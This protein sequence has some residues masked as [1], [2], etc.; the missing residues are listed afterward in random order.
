MGRNASSRSGAA[1]QHGMAQLNL[2]QIGGGMDIMNYGWDGSKLNLKQLWGG[3][4]M[5]I[6]KYG[7]DGSKLNLY[8]S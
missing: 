3:I 8:P 7:W 2:K 6:I 4:G 1:P 5:D